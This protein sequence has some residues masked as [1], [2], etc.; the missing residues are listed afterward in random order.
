[1]S[2][3]SHNTSVKCSSHQGRSLQ[4]ELGD[5]WTCKTTLASAYVLHYLSA[6]WSQLQMMGRSPR[7][8]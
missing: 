3:V 5:E 6:T 1:M 8:E 2:K 4:N 7:W